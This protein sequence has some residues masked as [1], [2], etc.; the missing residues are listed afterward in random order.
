MGR[1]L[2]GFF[3]L[4]I[5][6]LIWVSAAL[7][8][9]GSKGLVVTGASDTDARTAAES[10]DGTDAEAASDEEDC[11]YVYVTGAV[12]NP[13][14]YAM[15]EGDRIFDVIEAAGGFTE[16]ALETDVNLAQI[17]EDEQQIHIPTAEEA[18]LQA[19][20]D[21]AAGLVNINTAT[22]EELCTLTGIGEAKAQAIISYREE[23]GDFTSTEEIM[24]I[25]GIKE[26]VYEKI[27]DQ[28]TVG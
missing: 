14:V 22:L 26:G 23:Y 24:N 16:D 19:E 15:H 9:C 18:Q 21:E 8:G 27:K 6:M 10:S 28:I 12:V 11:I 25:S 17:I 7:C 13:G 1:R 4:W 3:V 2:H 5:G 20:A